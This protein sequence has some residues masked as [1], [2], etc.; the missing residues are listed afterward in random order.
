MLNFGGQ[1]VMQQARPRVPQQPGRSAGQHQ[2]PAGEPAPNINHYNSEPVTWAE[3][4]AASTIAPGGPLDAV[5][6]LMERHASSNEP[7]NSMLA[8]TTSSAIPLDGDTSNQMH[9]GRI[10]AG[11]PVAAFHPTRPWPARPPPHHPYRGATPRHPYYSQYPRHPPYSSVMHPYGVSP[12]PMLGRRQH[13]GFPPHMQY[14]MPPMPGYGIPT[15]DDMQARVFATSFVSTEAQSA[16]MGPGPGP[17]DQDPASGVECLSMRPSEAGVLGAPPPPPP[18]GTSSS[19]GGVGS[20]GGGAAAAAAAAAAAIGVRGGSAAAAAAA[21]P[22]SFPL[23]P[24]P[25]HLYSSPYGVPYR[26]RHMMYSYPPPPHYYNQEEMGAPYGRRLTGTQS[27]PLSGYS[28]PN[29]ASVPTSTGGTAAAVPAPA[30]PPPG[31]FPDGAAAGTGPQPNDSQGPP[32]AQ[33]DLNPQNCHPYG[34]YGS[35]P[36]GAHPFS[37]TQPMQ[38]SPQQQQQQLSSDGVTA[39]PA[40]AGT[41]AGDAATAAAIE[42]PSYPQHPHHTAAAFNHFPAGHNGS[43]QT[44]QQHH[45]LESLH[46]ASQDS[47]RRA[48]SADIPQIRMMGAGAASGGGAAA[49][50]QG[51]LSDGGAATAAAAVMAA[52]NADVMAQVDAELPLPLPLPE[53]LAQLEG[54]PN[55]DADEDEQLRAELHGFIGDLAT[56]GYDGGGVMHHHH[57]HHHHHHPNGMHPHMLQHQHQHQHLQYQQHHQQHH[58]HHQQQQQQQPGQPPHMR[59]SNGGAG[60]SLRAP[61]LPSSQQPQPQQQQLQHIHPQPQ[62]QQQQQQQQHPL[63]HQHPQQ[64]PGVQLSPQQQQQQQQQQQHSLQQ[65]LQP[66]QPLQPPQQ[67]QRHGQQMS[68]G[69][70]R[71]GPSSRGGGSDASMTL[72]HSSNQPMGQITAG[73]LHPLPPWDASL[74]GPME[75]LG[76]R[77]P[78]SLQPP[79][80]PARRP[81]Q[82]PSYVTH[83]SFNT[84]AGSVAKYSG[85]GSAEN[86][87][88]L[89]EGEVVDGGQPAGGSA[90]GNADGEGGGGVD[91]DGDAEAAAEDS[92]LPGGSAGGSAGG[93]RRRVTDDG[94]AN[95]RRPRRKTAVRR[96]KGRATGVPSRRESAGGGAGGLPAGVASA[97]SGDE[98]QIGAR[99]TLEQLLSQ[100]V[101]TVADLEVLGDLEPQTV[102][103]LLEKVQRKGKGGRAP[104]EDPRLDPSIDPRKARRILANRISAARSKLKQKL[105]L[106]G[107]KAR[108]QQLLSSKNEYSRELAELKRSCKELEARNRGLAVKLKVGSTPRGPDRT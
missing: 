96:V 66:L 65:P 87:D 102:S 104:A 53:L 28:G 106:E 21:L 82:Q 14:G 74:T 2:V 55:P 29:Y 6:E 36:Y 83:G 16:A 91:G 10:P 54:S 8:A 4:H 75:I 27:M 11:A 43:H 5:P 88:E 101:D 58:H 103:A 85:G 33:G 31:A 24:L 68:M 3:R 42:T 79:L 100:S 72:G 40:G 22:G 15:E 71:R 47:M 76:P 30:P 67:Q 13:P 98:L 26:P 64:P 63:A 37:P 84:A 49:A 62:Q 86:G 25:G 34:P 12:P 108:Y 97:A 52:A 35:P 99:P 41:P 32:P 39:A 23:G 57:H 50:G 51:T 93:G 9:M 19:E 81:V 48:F 17:G 59:S 90:D 1:D 77:G 69:P 73:L 7:G 56:E 44:H 18:M 107:L 70:V 94:E 38:P 46:A 92:W 89:V 105:I 78:M 95:Q 45:P 80:G 20:G 60:S 61:S